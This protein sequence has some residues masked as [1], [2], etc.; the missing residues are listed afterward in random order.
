M[1]AKTMEPLTPEEAKVIEEKGTEAP[2]SGKLLGEIRPGRYLCRKCGNPLFP[3][4][5]KFDAGCGW[6]SFDA[7]YPGAVT[8]TPDADGVRTEISCARCGGH[9]G[10]VFTG[11]GMTPKNT[12]HCANSVSLVFEP[13]RPN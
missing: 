2:F 8:A 6:P 7:H 4:A 9:L 1:T 3:A 13:E 5:A 12:R 10:H 11:E